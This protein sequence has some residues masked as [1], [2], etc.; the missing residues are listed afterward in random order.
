MMR[1][2]GGFVQTLLQ[3][4]QYAFRQLR[5]SPGFTITAVLTL[6]I[7]I[8]A[9][10]AS[11]SI[12][13]AVV[14]RPLAVPELNHVV[15]VYEQQSHGDSRQVALAN[16]EDWKRQSQSFEELAVRSN[17]DMSMTGA[18]DAA[19]VQA[20][21]TSP[22]FF[23]V[24][25]T[26]AFLGRVF[27]QNET[28][29]GRNSVA[30]L[31]YGFW[32]SHFGADAGILGR[33]IELDQHAYTVI[34]VMPKAMQYPA[35]ADFFLP[36]AP[37]AAQLADRSA[38]DYL[39]IGRL[40]RGLTAGQAQAEMN[41]IEDQLSH[42]YPTTNQGWSV[43]VE[44]L[45]ADM[46]GDLTPLYFNLI[47]GAT[48]FVLLVVCANV[49][50]LQFARGIRRRP[51]I[52][53]RT[54]L[55]AGRWRLLRQLLT[56]NIL[57]G[58]IGGAGG[59][60]FAVIDLHISEISMP[61]RV[62][63]FMAGWS[64]ISLNG[65]A[66]AF[67]LMLAVVA[68]VISGFAPALQALRVDLVDQ[69]KSGSRAVA[70]SGRSRMLRNILAVSQISLAVALVIGAA[71][72]CKGM[73]AMLHLG[74]RYQPA[75]V[76]TF[77]VHLPAARYDT[78]EK[79]AGWY[80][81]SLERLRALPG[82]THAEVTGAL[83][84]SDDGWLDECQIENRLRIP[85]KSPTALRMPVSAGYFDAFHTPLALGITSGRTFSPSDDLH[86]QPVTVVSR[87]FASRYFP[88]DSPL[89]HRIR[90]GGAGINQTPWMTIVGVVEETSYSLWDRSRPAAV[91]MNAA[92][93]PPVGM[94]YSI[95]TNGDPLAI[96]AVVRKALGSLDPTLPLDGVETYAQ[97]I[98]EK[99]TGMFYVAAMLGFDALIALLLA[100][101]GIFGV[102]ANLV[103][104]RTREIGVRLAMGARREDV[105][106]M[107]LRRAGWLTGAG[108]CIGLLMAFGLAR[109]VANLLYQ[110]RPDDP[111]VFGT[112]TVAI[113]G[114][115]LVA[116]WLP[117]R[118][119]AHIDPV[120]ALRDE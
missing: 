2:T 76:L 108:V 65:R 19:H 81:G 85:G 50:N 17:A 102:M 37:S 15:T 115:A 29:L 64:N 77:N 59:I 88:S 101:I 92:Q 72:M 105:L 47:Q 90:M 20:E 117:A 79:L 1:E 96:A 4:L 32:K 89:G 48:F 74:D 3:D 80:S 28:Q 24:M 7:G 16:F 110:V 98:H 83:P 34:G 55:G 120:R 87:E 31:S 69:L 112:I 107:I 38:H 44:T 9:N 5:K 40:R 91:Y 70:G 43:K 103:G 14:L 97:F 51:E 10:T 35:T 36:F 39:V 93:L 66:L 104:E 99:L 119:A 84:Y 116:S 54:A 86:S 118:W 75:Q 26:N 60:V 23:S 111:V 53:M 114:I 71:L 58:L 67:S 61:E 94:T 82:V 25:R 68:G 45:L 12:M 21:Y 22:S 18:G 113:T 57:L 78:P 100:A 63:R 49:A 30:V 8:G 106:R 6:A 42:A 46:N 13:D 95:T 41:V 56:E 33:K 73:F 62:A 109:M 52:A 27:D 11:F